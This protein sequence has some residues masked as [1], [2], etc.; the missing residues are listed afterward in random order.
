MGTAL[1]HTVSPHEIKKDVL[2]ML[3]VDEK[4]DLMLQYC[5]PRQNL[6]KLKF[7][8]RSLLLSKDLKRH[9]KKSLWSCPFLA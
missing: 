6:Y 5:F 9:I 2:N 8:F 7:F 3:L 1:A 4:V